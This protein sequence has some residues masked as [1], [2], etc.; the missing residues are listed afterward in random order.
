M[1]DDKDVKD[2]LIVDIDETQLALPIV[3][4]E[5]EVEIKP[6][7]KSEEVKVDS[8]PPKK[9]RK[10]HNEDVIKS[11][12]AQIKAKDDQLASERQA[13]AAAEAAAREKAAEA[14]QAKAHSDQS[15]RDVVAGRIAEAKSHE[16][17]IK[18]EMKQALEM[19]EHDRFT[20]LQ[21]EAARIAARK[22]QYED[23]KVELDRP[24]A[25]HVEKTEIRPGTHP[26]DDVEAYI[27]SIPSTKS[28]SWL[29]QHKECVTD[30]YLHS[31]VMYGHQE[32]IRKGIVADS[33]EYFA[34]L[35]QHMGYA[36]V[37][38]D[39]DGDED[40]DEVE[41]AT[42]QRK[43]M[44]SAPPS[45]DSVRQTGQIAP[46]KYRLTREE[47]AVAESMGLTATEYATH[48][49]KMIK[50]GRWTN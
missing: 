8:E 15:Y 48:K 22:L 46:G 24:K 32:A 17:R 33:P 45:R 7:A 2:D 3:K 4:D 1:K 43:S 25:E 10:R 38:D 30:P 11:L 34:H 28:Q 49:V 35:D 6:E 16:E 18:R 44:A 41:V 47:A 39:D 26:R 23:A 36:D 29:R 31:K 42:P 12:E 40:G 20:D 14:S 21:M 37:N 13:R 9:E 50:E 27:Q 19:G 5:L